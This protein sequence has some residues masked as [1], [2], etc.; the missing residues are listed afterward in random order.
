MP[1]TT[2]SLRHDR[3]RLDEFY[4]PELAP[5]AH[6]DVVDLIAEDDTVVGRFACSATHP[7][8]WRGHQPTG[9]RFERI[10]EVYIFRFR[11]HKIVHA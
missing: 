1:E 7:G 5:A 10:A 8:V 4:A 2:V 6:M 3:H 11:D 9:R